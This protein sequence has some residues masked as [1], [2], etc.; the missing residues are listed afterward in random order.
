M[1]PTTTQYLL[2]YISPFS[3][4][5]IIFHT[6]CKKDGLVMNWCDPSSVKQIAGRA[7]RLSS[8]YKHGVVTAW[9]VII[10]IF[11]TKKTLG[12]W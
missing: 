8:N 1:S 11:D 3:F 9:Q 6:A 12:I 7:G 10:K 2:S 5:R 4:N